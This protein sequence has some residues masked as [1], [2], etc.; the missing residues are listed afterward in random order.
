MKCIKNGNK[1]E[2]VSD[3]EAHKRVTKQGWKYCPK[4]EYKAAQKS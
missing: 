4:A 3:E 1:I 2:R